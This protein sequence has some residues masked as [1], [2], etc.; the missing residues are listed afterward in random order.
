[1][2]PLGRPV[3]PE[4]YI[5]L[6]SLPAPGGSGRGQARRP[7]FRVDH[8]QWLRALAGDPLQIC[9]AASGDHGEV[10]LGVLHEIEHLVV[11]V[12]R[13]YGNDGH[14]ERVEGQEMEE[15]LRPVLEEEG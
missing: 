14:T 6:V 3:V 9:H 11:P 13:V 7:A 15:E 10:R 1:M 12:V 5:K 4:V 2:Q 8:W